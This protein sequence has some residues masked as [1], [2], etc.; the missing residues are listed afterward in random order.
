MART[1]RARTRTSNTRVQ[2]SATTATLKKLPANT[3]ENLVFDLAVVRGLSNATWRTP[4]ADGGRDIQ[5]VFQRD[6]FSGESVIERWY[7]ECKRYASAVDWPT[8]FAKV[9][10]AR[11]QRADS[12]ILATTSFPSPACRTEIERYNSSGER[13]A[14]RVWDGATLA[15][16]LAVTP[17]IAVKYGLASAARESAKAFLDLALLVTRAVHA[18][19]GHYVGTNALTHQL[20]FAASAADLLLARFEASHR[21]RRWQPRAFHTKRDKYP[22]C[23]TSGTASCKLDKFGV[24]FA[25]AFVRYLTGKNTLNITVSDDSISI[26]TSRL[27]LGPGERATLRTLSLWG[28]CSVSASAHR[29]IMKER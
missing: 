4:G 28:D 19:Y 26:S 22:W 25:L 11:N 29:V 1:K 15:T 5:G 8:V 27:I 16:Y 20:E 2:T 23:L 10:Y 24:R 13:P 17:E 12:L 14:I 3:F 6:D 21:Q 9:A 7:I 18:S